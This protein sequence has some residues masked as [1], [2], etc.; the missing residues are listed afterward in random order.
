MWRPP[1]APFEIRNAALAEPCVISQLLL[2]EP[3]P[4]T[5]T[6]QQYAELAWPVF[7]H[8]CPRRDQSSDLQEGCHSSVRRWEDFDRERLWPGDAAP[9][10]A[11]VIGDVSIGLTGGHTLKLGNANHGR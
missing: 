1:P 11:L 10:A 6:L 9:R 3:G 4:V 8:R 2:G 5:M 7:R